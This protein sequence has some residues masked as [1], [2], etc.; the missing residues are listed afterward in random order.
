MQTHILA[1]VKRITGINNQEADAVYQ[2]TH[3]SIRDFLKHF[4]STFPQP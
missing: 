4:R 3:L 2:L 1:S